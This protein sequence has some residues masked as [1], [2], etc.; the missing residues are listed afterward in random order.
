LSTLLI[1]VTEEFRYVTELASAALESV[2]EVYGVNKAEWVPSILKYVAPE[3]IR[4][5]F[6][7]TRPS[8]I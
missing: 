2:M 8:G 1:A 4:S 5:Q 6:G 7:G 3:Q